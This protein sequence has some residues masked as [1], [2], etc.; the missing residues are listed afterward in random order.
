MERLDNERITRARYAN[1]QKI[2]EYTHRIET[3]KTALR[4]QVELD[5]NDR[6]WQVIHATSSQ[7]HTSSTV[8]AREAWRNSPLHSIA[9]IIH[10]SNG[11]HVTGLED[12]PQRQALRSEKRNDGCSS[13]KTRTTSIY[14]MYP[15]VIDV[16]E[17]KHSSGAISLVSPDTDTSIME[18]VGKYTTRC[19]SSI[20]LGR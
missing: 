20:Q 19:H 3:V 15:T 4:H 17:C 18:F 16:F 6:Y 14:V 10:A 7:C 5:L 13:L 2:K 8:L 1:L 12:R 9:L 11:K